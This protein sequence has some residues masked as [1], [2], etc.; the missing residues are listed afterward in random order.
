MAEIAARSLA[1]GRVGPSLPLILGI[2]V[3]TWLL[4][5]A[6]GM[7]G[8][9]DTYW[10]IAVGRWIIAHGAVPHHGIFSATM[11][12]A[13]WIAHEWLAEIAIAGVYEHFGWAGVIAATA[14]CV[15]AA[16]AMLLRA[17]LHTLEPAHALM[18]SVLATAMVLPHLLARP[19]VLILPI[20]VC[21]A[22][23][24]VAARGAQRAPSLFLAPLMALWANLHASYMLGLGLATML[25]ADAILAASDR[26]GRLAAIRGWGQ[27]AA[28]SIAAALITPYG[29]DGLLLPINLT[30]MSSLALIKEW[31]S[32]DFQNF[33]PLELW[34][35]FV[36]FA[37][38]SLGLRLPPAR[39][40]IV[41]LLLHMA[42]RHARYGELLG[43]LAPLLLAPALAPQLAV[44]ATRFAVPALDRGL[45]GLAKPA[46]A[47]G[48][49]IAG[50]VLLAVS[51]IPLR[52]DIAPRSDAIT[53]AEAL[54]A[55]NA[56]HIQGPVFND[57]V[58]GGYLIFSG[59]EPFI[60]G[61]AELYGD[62]FIKRYLDAVSIVSGRL[63]QL[64]AQ[65]E[66]TWTLLSP[67]TPAARLLDNLPG[68]RRLYAD[69]VAVV[70]VREDPVSR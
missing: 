10:H 27:F 66:V 20:L 2:F 41:L 70:H 58:F 35:A 59:F 64:L 11:A 63:P 45:A 54:A 43:F 22:T 21:W 53:P 69:D 37:A 31:Q 12:A 50:I 30:N 49:A 55:V 56:R 61:R 16:L 46:G 40:A 36:F 67:A 19:H 44:Y 48:V 52:S 42:L 28:L 25:T 4:L 5:G 60:D 9:P 18:A 14:L 65:Y 6:P 38:F 23:E 17:L 8:D 33:Q 51:A 15:A 26:R 29:I 32:P 7:L 62:A 68:W 34:I 39:I 57:Y 1:R 3:Y 13:P 24:L 47:G